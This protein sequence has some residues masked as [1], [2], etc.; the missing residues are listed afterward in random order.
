MRGHPHLITV[1]HVGEV[2]RLLYYT[3]DLAD[4]A[5]CGPV[6]DTFPPQYHPLTLER[7]LRQRRLRIDVAMEIIR[8]L[9][10]GLAALHRK[11]LVHRDVKPSNIVFVDRRPQLAD[12]GIMTFQPIAISWSKRKRGR[13]QRI[14]SCSRQTN[15]T[16]AP[17]TSAPI[18]TPKP[19]C[20]G[21]VEKPR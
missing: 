15:R 20:R 10:D 2:G 14:W 18:R 19:L 12:I 6:R 17:N 21:T 1:Y 7:I 8:R 3:M 5:T 13:V 9:L 4:D 11:G 16:L